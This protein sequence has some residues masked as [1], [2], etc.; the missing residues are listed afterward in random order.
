M[1][2]LA[3]VTTRQIVRRIFFMY[4]YSDYLIIGAGVAGCTLAWLLRQAGR[5]A[6]L[7][8]LRDI[9]T[10]D[11]LCGGALGDE[12]MRMM[13]TIFGAGAID[14]LSPVH[15]PLMRLRCLDRELSTS[16][17]FYTLPRKRLDDWMLR[18]CIDMG[19][20]VLDRMHIKAIDEK[21]HMVSCEDLRSRDKNRIG[22]GTLIGAD[23]AAS[24]VRRLLGG[25]RQSLAIALEG[26]VPTVDNDIVFEY[27]PARVGY[28][29]YIP[30]GDTANIGCGLYEG[31]PADAREWLDGFCADM[32]VAP[33]QLRGAPIPSGDDVLLQVGKGAW[34]IGDAAGLIDPINGGGIHY[35]LDSAYKFARSLQ[36]GIPYA[37]AMSPDIEK[38]M[39]MAR[40][41]EVRYLSIASSIACKG[42]TKKGS[43]KQ[44]GV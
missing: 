42:H 14:E 15:H 13:E 44:N 28:C 3:A 37:K 25:N 5:E 41:R 6:L 1:R 34:L 35:A 26:I 36:G 32:Q 4:M 24:T 39:Q 43:K 18:S 9:K 16:L 20:R 30:T 2:L 40:I 21:E 10:K 27:H 33:S 19:V 31:T 12:A 29:W 11:K 17:R 22:Y 7:L 38:I 23:G 8:E